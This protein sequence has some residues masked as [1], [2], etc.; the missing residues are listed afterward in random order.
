VRPLPSFRPISGIPEA[1]VTRPHAPSPNLAARAGGSI[2]AVLAACLS[3]AGCIYGFQAGAGFPGYVRTVAIV[4]FEN[5]TNRPELT[6]EVFLML[7]RE[8]PRSQGLQP[9]GEDVADAVVRGRIRR[10]DLSTPSYRPGAAGETPQVL[11]RQVTLVVE[12]QIINLVDNTILWENPG[13]SVQGQFLEETESE[14][15]GRALA[16]ELLIQRIVDGAQENW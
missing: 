13:I 2:I 12:V 16:I 6:D 1:R 11:Q 8:F 7:L 9:A 15:I 10:Y 3:L 14:D 4:P 5:E